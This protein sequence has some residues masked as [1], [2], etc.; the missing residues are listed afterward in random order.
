VQL[1]WQSLL[2]GFE[3]IISQN[4]VSNTCLCEATESVLVGAERAQLDRQLVYICRTISLASSMFAHQFTFRDPT[5][6]KR[7]YRTEIG[8]SGHLVKC[9]TN[10]C[11]DLLLVLFPG[12]AA[13]AVFLDKR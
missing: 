12:P 4:L 2:L 6:S 10:Q 13:A 8:E 1:Q 3:V 9:P 5:L 7:A 11:L